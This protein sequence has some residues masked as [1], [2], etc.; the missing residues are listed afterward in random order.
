MRY[1]DPMRETPRQWQHGRHAWSLRFLG[2][3]A[4]FAIA[5]PFFA[6]PHASAASVGD[7]GSAISGVTSAG[8]ATIE[9]AVTALP[10]GPSSPAPVVPQV[11]APVPD[12]VD[13]IVGPLEP[14]G[15]VLEP[16]V[17]PLEPV[18]GPVVEPVVD[19]LPPVVGPIVAPVEPVVGPVVGPLEPVGGPL[20]PVGSLP[21]PGAVAGP[22]VGSEVTPTVPGALSTVPGSSGSGATGP[23]AATDASSAPQP[24]GSVATTAKDQALP[25]PVLSSVREA[26][27]VVGAGCV[28]RWMT[29]G[30]S[31]VDVAGSSVTS[32]NSPTPLPPSS[33]SALFGTLP[34]AP[35]TSLDVSSPFLLLLFAIGI[36]SLLVFLSPRVRR[37]APYWLAEARFLLVSKAKRPG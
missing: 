23:S 35:S 27:A 13:P 33:P 1:A 20:P 36:A 9:Q 26:S 37:A 10:V 16:V 28:P 22:I 6:G 18:V 24:S 29:S 14:V 30:S 3:S 8:G 34:W 15:P 17:A 11:V 5:V 12:V 4:L 7:L 25:K 19:P 2:L 21:P 31:P 32:G